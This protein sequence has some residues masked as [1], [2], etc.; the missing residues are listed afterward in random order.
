MGTETRL[1][2]APGNTAQSTQ[3]ARRTQYA[4]AADPR[5]DHGRQA[6]QDHGDVVEHIRCEAVHLAF[7]LESRP[8]AMCEEDRGDSARGV[9]QDMQQQSGGWGGVR[10]ADADA[11]EY[12]S[13][14][15]E[16]GNGAA[17]RLE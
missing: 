6:V 16:T 2:T 8:D 13:G 4:D 12:G 5:G 7:G 1:G 15:Q 9:L 3:H 17:E 10:I 14:G 11:L